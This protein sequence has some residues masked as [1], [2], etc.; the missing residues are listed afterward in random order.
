MKIVDFMHEVGRI[1]NKPASWKDMFFR[2]AY[3]LNGS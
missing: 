3:G 2:E 1:K